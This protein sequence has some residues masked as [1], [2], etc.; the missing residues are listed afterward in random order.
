MQTCV[1]IE[2]GRAGWEIIGM[3]NVIKILPKL[4]CARAGCFYPWLDRADIQIKMMRQ[5]DL[6]YHT[7]HQG[8]PNDNSLYK[9]QDAP[10]HKEPPYV[11]MMAETDIPLTASPLEEISTQNGPPKMNS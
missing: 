1:M 10:N 2:D 3:N 6:H 4:V 8:L 7:D 5:I 11:K 9:L